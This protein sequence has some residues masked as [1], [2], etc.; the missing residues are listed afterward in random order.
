[1]SDLRRPEPVDVLALLRALAPEDRDK[2]APAR[3]Q[4]VRGGD[5]CLDALA[6]MA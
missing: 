1:L 6:V 4:A 5:A 3:A 2:P